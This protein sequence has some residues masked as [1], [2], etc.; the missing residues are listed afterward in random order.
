MKSR[1]SRG[2]HSINRLRVWAIRLHNRSFRCRSSLMKIRILKTLGM[3]KFVWNLMMRFCIKNETV[4]GVLSLSLRSPKEC[5][6]LTIFLL[7]HVIHII[8]KCLSFEVFPICFWRNSIASHR[9]P[10]TGRRCW[11]TWIVKLWVW[12]T[13]VI[14]RRKLRSTWCW[15]SCTKVIWKS[16]RV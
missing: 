2:I 7:L 15:W 12:G 1:C 4:V 11:L 10:V 9:S 13:Y 8:R 16:A 6:M 5:S 3:L 14:Y